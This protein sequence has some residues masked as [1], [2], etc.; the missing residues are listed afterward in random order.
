MASRALQTLAA[1]LL[2]GVWGVALGVLY[3]RGELGFLDRVEAA[4]ADVRTVIR[5]PKPPPQFVT[6]VAIDDDT[7][8]K[9]G[10]YPLPRGVLARLVAEI[11]RQAPK[12]IAVDLLLLDSGADGKDAELARALAGSPAVIA[13]AA[14]FAGGTE[15]VSA[16]V[17]DLTSE[18]P[19]A[20]RFLLPLDIFSASAAVGVVNVATDPTGTPRFLPLFFRAGDRLEASL[21]LRVAAM[22]S[23]ADPQIEPNR[24]TLAG[25]TIAT[26]RGHLL[27]IDFYGPSGTI[28]TVSAATLLSGRMEADPLR[29]HVVVIGSTVTGGGDVF[30]TPFDAVLPGVEVV[31]TSIS[32]LMTDGGLVRDRRTR[33]ADAGIAVVLPM[34]IV[35]LIAWRRSALGLAAV[36]AVVAGWL[37]LNVVAFANGIWLSAT[38][39]VAAAAPPAILFGAAQMWLDRNRARRFATESELLQRV[40]APGLGA[41]LAGHRDFL[42]EPVEENA[43]VVFID[44]SGFTGISEAL[45]PGPTR[46]MLSSFHRLVDEEVTRCGGIVC[47]FMG[48][49]AMILFGLPEPAEKDACSAAEC[50]MKL[51][52]RTRD[53]LAAWPASVSSRLGFKIGAHYGTIVASRLG[54]ATHQHV[55]ATGDTVNVASRLM[56]IA[57]A[58]G[59]DMAMSDEMFQAT[60][61]DAPRFAAGRLQGPVETDIRG[62]SGSL[63]VWLWSACPASP[64]PSGAD[65]PPA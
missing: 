14:V 46:E 36:V 30:P 65:L 54:G 40:Q 60:G 37:V 8:G 23:G 59:A 48:D 13:A 43:A 15:A 42:A 9:A 6:I 19:E 5:G 10:Q 28:R 56:E 1:L 33:L 11:D 31:A 24:L 64:Q 47:S 17:D 55:T 25:R 3:L 18:L 62:R 34:V 16:D 61:C 51:A 63:S 26:D 41:W 49:G 50:G 4:M 29:N 58:H 27:P 57:A 7:A 53:W 44:L 35:A 45:G 38:L 39:P 32:N 20:E 21:P 2:A 52:D 12:A 22:A